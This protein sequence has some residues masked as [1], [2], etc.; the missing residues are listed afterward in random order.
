[1]HYIEKTFRVPCGHRLSKHKGLCKNPHGHGFTC[2]ITLKAEKLN[3]ND[4]IIDFTTLKS[5]VN[6]LIIIPMDHALILNEDDKHLIKFEEA[7]DFKH[8]KI[9]G[10]PTAENLSKILFDTIDDHIEKE[11]YEFKIHSVKVWENE[12]SA[13]IYMK[14]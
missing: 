1:M 4:M 9:I 3:E 14:E 5:I 12:D 13:A 11:K 6:N 8:V 10:D 2:I 7:H